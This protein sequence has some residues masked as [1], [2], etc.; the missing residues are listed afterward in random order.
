MHTNVILNNRRRIHAEPNYTNTIVKAWFRRLLHH[1]AKKTEWAYSTALESHVHVPGFHYSQ[2]Y[3]DQ[4]DALNHIIS[5]RSNNSCTVHEM[6]YYET[7]QNNHNQ[8]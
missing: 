4:S 2:Y 5:H 1:P 7:S 6:V 8:Q 3:Q